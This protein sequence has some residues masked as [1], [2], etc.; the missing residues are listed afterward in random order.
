MVVA[1]LAVNTL[2]WCKAGER[3]RSFYSMEMEIQLQL[4]LAFFLR[5]SFFNFFF[6]QLM[7]GSKCAIV[8]YI[9][10]LKGLQ[11]TK[12]PNENY[13]SCS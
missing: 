1:I 13:I 12:N 6:F 7:K 2:F 3:T 5:I 4:K 8:L 11:C 9:A 10:F